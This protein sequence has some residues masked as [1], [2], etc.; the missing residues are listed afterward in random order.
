[1]CIRDRK[2]GKQLYDRWKKQK[3]IIKNNY[4]CK[5]IYES[6][7]RKMKLKVQL[8]NL[9]YYLGYIYSVIINNLKKVFNT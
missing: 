6:M 2:I 9:N 3:I 8:F 1:M 5:E 4:L 7:N